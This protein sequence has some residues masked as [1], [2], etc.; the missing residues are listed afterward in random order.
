MKET[1]FPPVYAVTP[2]TNNGDTIFRVWSIDNAISLGDG[3]PLNCE[4]PL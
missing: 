2:E 3:L 4:Q 1:H